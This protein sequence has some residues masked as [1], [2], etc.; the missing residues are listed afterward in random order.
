M[1]GLRVIANP[2][3]AGSNDILTVAGAR[4]Q[5]FQQVVTWVLSKT[6]TDTENSR[7]ADELHQMAGTTGCPNVL[8]RKQQEP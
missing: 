6:G 1:A 2:G 5:D 3:G 7:I 8:G 4:E